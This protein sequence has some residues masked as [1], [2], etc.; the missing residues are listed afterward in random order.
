MKKVVSVSLGSSKRDHEVQVSILGEE[1][2]IARRGTD[3]NFEAALKLLAELDGEVDAIGLGGIDL[4][5]YSLKNRYVIKDAIRMK[6]AVKK[7]PVVDGSG[8]KNTLEREIIKRLAEDERF[9]LQGKK[10][11]MVSGLDRFGMAQTFCEAGCRMVYGDFLFSLGLEKPL[12]TLEELEHYAEKLLP[13][14]S[15][16]PFDM[17]YPTGKKQDKQKKTSTPFAEYYREAEIIA[18]DFHYIYKYMPPRIPGKIIVTNTV[19]KDNLRELSERGVKYLVATTPEFSGRSFGTNVLE[20]VLLT[21]LGKT[22]QEV[23][24][25]D[26]LKMIR[27]LDLKP[28]IEILN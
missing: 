13:L 10:V 12:Y 25:E 15:E 7:T 18:G 11:L 1:F 26:Y 14:I 24:A 20:G 16:L 28:R 9:A 4:Y 5:L 27:E 8:L 17:I 2:S 3:G 21:L 22:A 19:T 23:T 6:D